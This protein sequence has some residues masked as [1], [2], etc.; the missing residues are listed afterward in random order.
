MGVAVAEEKI[1]KAVENLRTYSSVCGR[2][3]VGHVTALAKNPKQVSK[4]INIER[5]LE[6][7]GRELIGVCKT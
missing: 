1:G 7:L 4:D 6:R 2:L 3:W 5:R